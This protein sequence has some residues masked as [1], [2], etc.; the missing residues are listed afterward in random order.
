MFINSLVILNK[1]GIYF[2]IYL[3]RS[4]SAIYFAKS[5]VSSQPEIIR[6][7]TN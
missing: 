2:A 4:Y 7:L 1:A 5:L 3:E 6:N